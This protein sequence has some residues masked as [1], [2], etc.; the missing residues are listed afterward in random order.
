MEG[1]G[2]GYVG[3][4]LLLLSYPVYK[5]SHPSGP[6]TSGHTRLIVLCADVLALPVPLVKTDLAIYH[7][8]GTQFPSQFTPAL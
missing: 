1:F 2:L 8:P 7:L 3:Q 5:P 6:E 4:G